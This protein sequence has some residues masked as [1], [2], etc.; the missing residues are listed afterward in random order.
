MGLLA[1][2]TSSITV[3]GA[4][5]RALDATATATREVARVALRTWM[6]LDVSGA[7]HVPVTGGA[8]VAATHTS[9]ADSLALG[10]AVRRRLSFLGSAD[11]AET[12][13]LGPFLPRIGLLPVERGSGDAGLLDEL[14]ELVA[15]GAALVV[16]P[17]GSRSRDGSVHRPRSGVARLAAATGAPVVPA[18]VTGSAEAWP[19]DAWPRPWPRARVRVR[20]RAPLAPPVDRPLDRRQWNDHLHED[21]VALSG[22]PRTDELAPMGGRT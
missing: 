18:G 15:D 7:H 20:F 22:R 12:P 21:L 6:A 4:A 14:A 8:I 9:H 2:S 11:L 13:V 10:A 1:R 17:E 16:Y 5:D 19:V 3:S